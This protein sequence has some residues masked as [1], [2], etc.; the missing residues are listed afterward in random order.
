MHLRA[1]W[2]FWAK[3]LWSLRLALGSAVLQAVVFIIPMVTPLH[4]SIWFI[5]ISALLQLAAG[6]LA[7][8]AAASTLVAQP[9]AH[10]E[11]AAIKGADTPC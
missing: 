9:Q 1:D 8:A 5:V 10:A 2:E 7:L 6:L 4:P 11:I 3:K